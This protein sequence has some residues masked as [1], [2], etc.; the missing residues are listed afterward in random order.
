MY[1]FKQKSEA[2]M[3]QNFAQVFDIPEPKQVVIAMGD[4]NQNH[5]RKFK[6]PTKGKYKY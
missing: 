4:W 3:L 6:E 1:I 2:K 5:H